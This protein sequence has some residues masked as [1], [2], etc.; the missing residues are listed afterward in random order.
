MTR[1]KSPGY[2]GLSIEHLKYAGIYLPDIL[3]MFYTVCIGHSY[4]PADMLRTVVVPI[5]KSKT[6]D[7]SDKSNYRPISLA[8]IL[9]KVLDGLLNTR[10]DTYVQIHDNQFGF[11]PGLSARA[12]LTKCERSEPSFKPI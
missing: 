3:A 11:K 6:G 1:G 8:T 9:A 5:V 10:L 4:L 2:D 12:E 7:I